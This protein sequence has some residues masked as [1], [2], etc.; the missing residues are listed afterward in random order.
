MRVHNLQM[1]RRMPMGPSRAYSH[2]F[3]PYIKPIILPH[4]YLI[5]MANEG[6]ME[7]IQGGFEVKYGEIDAFDDWHLLLFLSS[8]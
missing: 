1:G 6:D 2:A 5:Y 7:I 8:R 4:H 3:R